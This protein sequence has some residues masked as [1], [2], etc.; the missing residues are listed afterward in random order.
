MKFITGF[1]LSI[2]ILCSNAHGTEQYSAIQHKEQL[3]A[4]ATEK[5]V[6]AQYDR[7]PKDYFLIPQNLPFMVGLS[8]YHPDNKALDLSEEQNTAIHAIR[9]QTVPAVLTMAG[10]IKK[11]EVELAEKFVVQ[12][13]EP[14]KLYALV[15]EIAVL[16]TKLTK[17][18]M[19]CIRDVQNVL[20]AKQYAAL[21]KVAGT[22]T[23][24]KKKHAVSK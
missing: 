3:T 23:H 14:Q 22:V 16:R 15:D 20:D 21:L 4:A 17:A 11:K 9:N 1:T 7:W 24:H 2:F 12:K 18:H 8:L 13:I 5:G 10:S 19:A 6:Y